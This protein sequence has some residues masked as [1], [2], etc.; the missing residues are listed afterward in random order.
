MEDYTNSS[1]LSKIS[2]FFIKNYRISIL[3]FISIFILGIASYTTFLRREGFPPV[4]FP[5]G[6]A[7]VPY[8][9]GD[10]DKVNEDVTEPIEQAVNEL[11]QVQEVRS[12]TTDNFAVF[13]FE[14]SQGISSQEG[15]D[16]VRDEIRNNADLPDGVDVNYIAINAASV[17]GESDFVFTISGDKTT[18][19]LQQKAQEIA[20]ELVKEPEVVNAT[21]NELITPQTNPETGEII[22]YQSGFNRVLFRED[23]ELVSQ[24][25]IAIGL[26]KKENVGIVEFSDIVRSDIDDLKKEGSLDGYN[27]QYSGDISVYV[28]DQLSA[29]ESNAISGFFVVILVL[30]LLVNWRASIVTALF[31]PTVLAAT[32]MTLFVTGITLN[33]ITLFSL[34]LV[35]GLFVDDAIVVVEAIDYQKKQGERGIQAVIKAVKTIGAADVAGSLTTILVFA[36]LLFISGVLG[37]FIRLIPVTVIISLTLSLLIALTLIPF[38]SNIVISDDKKRKLEGWKATVD[39]YVYG[40]PR[41]VTR[42]GEKV[43]EFV[44]FYLSKP[45]YTA[46]VVAVT[47]LLVIVGGFLPHS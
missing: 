14:F 43:G 5:I 4:E 13:Q 15:I 12:A 9:V 44:K 45:L 42:L 27:V 3:L 20:S 6:V 24:N 36:P 28:K 26:E 35:L 18:E 2:T 33:T 22:Q 7:N 37:E 21:V 8:F 34:I 47:L 31:I 19:E 46:I 16:M 32:F 30:F 11:K 29:L 1:F 38:L 23:G 39:K 25:A 40:V 17:D 10:V 41:L